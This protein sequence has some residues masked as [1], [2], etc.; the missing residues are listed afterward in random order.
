MKIYIGDDSGYDTHFAEIGKKFGPMDI[1][2]L[3]N[4]QYDLACKYIHTQP[5]EVLQA[6]KDLQAKRLLP[7]HSSKFTLGNHPWDEPLQPLKAIADI[8]LATPMIG[9]PVDLRNDRQE[10]EE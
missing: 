9:Q 10:F 8:P 6:A 4:G 2:I 7:V 5:E 1:A 3:E